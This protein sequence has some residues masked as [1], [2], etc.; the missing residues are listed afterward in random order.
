M[1][2]VKP[3]ILSVF[4]QIEL[5]SLLLVDEPAGTRV[6]Y[7]QRSGENPKRLPNGVKVVRR[8]TTIPRVELVVKDDAFWMRL[9]LFADMG[10]AESYMLGE[11]ECADLTSFFQVS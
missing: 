9:C 5:G 1:S 8:A 3:A 2:V 6:V 7:G 4:S 10:F 11:F